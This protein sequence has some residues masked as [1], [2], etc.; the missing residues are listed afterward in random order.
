MGNIL[1]QL[2][3]LIVLGCI[4]FIL[5]HIGVAIFLVTLAVAAIALIW[6]GIRFYLLRKNISEALREYQDTRYTSAF[7]RS[8]D[9]DTLQ[10]EVIDA[11]YEEVKAEKKKRD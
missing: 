5:L 11:E 9:E 6:F 7:E 8:R 3:A 2:F 10:G 1:R 4:F